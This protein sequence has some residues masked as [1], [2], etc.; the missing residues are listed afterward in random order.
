LGYAWRMALTIIGILFIRRYLYKKYWGH[1]GFLGRLIGLAVGFAFYI[2]LYRYDPKAAWITI[3][4]ESIVLLPYT[5]FFRWKAANRTRKGMQQLALEWRTP[6][7]VDPQSGLFQTVK[8]REESGE[9]VLWIGNV[10]IH[11]RSI[12]PAVRTEETYWGFACVLR[13]DEQPPFECSLI[14]GYTDPLFFEREWR[15][16]TRLKGEMTMLDVGDLLEEGCDTRVTGGK[17]E[18][19]QAYCS[20]EGHRWDQFQTLSGTHEERFHQ[21]FSGEILERFFL[22]ASS[23]PQYEMNVTPT[24]LNILTLY[25]RGDIQRRHLECLI[26]LKQR[27]HEMASEG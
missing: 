2:P 3:A 26:G 19:L 13:L 6:F 21:V 12:H 22:S 15:R 25:C 11:M 14:K 18:T 8:R 1:N 24:S 7:D 27:L 20:L 4:A 5:S 9:P 23:S 16:I 10:G 17:A